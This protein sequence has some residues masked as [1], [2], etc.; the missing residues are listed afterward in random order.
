MARRSPRAARRDVGSHAGLDGYAL[1]RRA[2]ARRRSGS[3]PSAP[4]ST[5]S[6]PRASGCS[7]NRFSPSAGSARTSTTRRSSVTAMTALA[8]NFLGGWLAIRVPLG[9]LMAIALLVLSLGL[10]ALPHVSTRLA[11]DGVGDGD[12]TRRRPRDGAVL[13]RLA[14][15][16]RTAAPRTHSGRGAGA[17][18]GRLGGR[19][20]A[21][22]L[23]RRRGPAATR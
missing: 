14:A 21:A 13:Q 4:R 9:R 15:R 2:R 20:A 18:R 23:V 3:S 8:G 22:R 11:G 12:G 6:S 16:V 17:D 1:E 5:A 19:P 10:V 7:T